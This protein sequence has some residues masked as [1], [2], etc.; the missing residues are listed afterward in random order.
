MWIADLSVAALFLGVAFLTDIPWL[1]PQRVTLGTASTHSVTA[2]VLD[3]GQK[4]T[5]LLLDSDR[6]VVYLPTGDVRR[7][8]NCDNANNEAAIF[9]ALYR[10]PSLFSLFL[11]SNDSASYRDCPNS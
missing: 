11:T 7:R 6:S 5:T 10:A 8:S 3:E 4:T 9:G 1:P 2:Y